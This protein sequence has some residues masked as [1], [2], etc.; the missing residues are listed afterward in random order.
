MGATS[1]FNF[2][3]AQGN[4]PALIFDVANGRDIIAQYDDGTEV[5]ALMPDGFIRTTSGWKYRQVTGFLG[6][7]GAN[8]DAYTYPLLRCKH[9]IT[10][11]NVYIGV[12]TTI[13]A[14]S[15]N[16]QTIYLENSGTT[17]DISTLTTAAGF[18]LHVPRAFS[19]LDSGAVKLAAGQTLSIRTVKTASGKAMSGAIVTVVYTIDQPETTV[20]SDKT[21]DNVFRL[22]ND[23]GTAA[24]IQLDFEQRPFLSVR[25]NGVEKLRVDIDGKMHGKCADQYYYHVINSTQLVTGDS[26][27]KKDV[28][29]KPHCSV[30]IE[31]IYFGFMTTDAADSQ[32][33][34]WQISAKD[35]SGNVLADCYVGGPYGSG[36]AVTKGI[37][38][39]M[40]DI[41]EEYAAL[42]STE[43]LQIE[44]LQTGT[45]PN[46][47][48]PTYV[49]C[50]RKIA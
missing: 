28:V 40:G 41:N 36:T 8:H 5:F 46:E 6:D 10:I 20:G 24:T 49:V 45:G 22:V 15:T 42:L 27:A 3:D 26:A 11:Q 34:Y 18:T 21:T 17:T 2:D 48:S 29:F 38:Y 7:L 35:N 4:G 50:Y 1:C 14:D 16:Y 47:D 19:S 25:Q 12:D 13:A 33:A 9:D 23:I 39:D 30:Q 44:Y 32:T 43:Q 31:A 37:L